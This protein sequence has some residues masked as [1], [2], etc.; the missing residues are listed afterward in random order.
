MAATRQKNVQKAEPTHYFDALGFHVRI[1]F[2]ITGTSPLLET[3]VTETH[4][5]VT[6]SVI[7][8]HGLGADGHDFAGITA[9]L[10]LPAQLGIRFIFPRAPV[11]P[12]TLNQGLAMRAWYDI[13]TLNNLHSEDRAGI[14]ASE[15]AIARLIQQQQATGIASTRIILAG[16]SQGG[17]LALHTGL[18]YPARLGGILGLSTYLPLIEHIAAEVRPENKQTPIFLAHGQ[19]DDVLPFALGEKTRD[20]L[21]AAGYPVEFYA[22]PMAHQMCLKEIA[23]ISRWLQKILC[24]PSL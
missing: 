12:V 22:Y 11:R 8:L 14:Q 9:Q 13:Y 17:A 7:W 15:Q 24:D 16:Y 21:Q 19:Y 20:Y 3:I 10:Q 2:M 1:H 5:P 23:D 6:A 4:A 18:R